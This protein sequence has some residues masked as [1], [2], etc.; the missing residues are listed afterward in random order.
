MKYV[1]TNVRRQDRL[2]DEKS[3]KKLLARGKYGVLSMQTKE[4]KAYGIPINYVWNGRQ[5]I[6][7]HSAPEGRKLESIDLYNSVSFCVIGKTKIISNKFTTA[8]E[9]I[10]M[11]CVAVRNLP[12]NE[13]IK[14][15]ELLIDKYSPEDKITGIEYVKKTINKTEIIR[16]DI[17]EYSGKSKKIIS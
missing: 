7:L 6:Y 14:A 12:N 9:S 5:S 2:L 8:Y 10:I 4:N 13:K 3:A 17:I 15:L 16:L 11:E 1:N